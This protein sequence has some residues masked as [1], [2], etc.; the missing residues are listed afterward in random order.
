MCRPSSSRSAGQPVSASD[1]AVAALAAWA[2]LREDED[3]E[4]EEEGKEDEDEDDEEDD[5]EDNEEALEVFLWSPSTPG[6]PAMVP[7]A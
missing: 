6:A 2:L 7:P 4:E 5:D 1:R 3:E